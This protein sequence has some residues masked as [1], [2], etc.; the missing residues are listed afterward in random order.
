MQFDLF[1]LVMACSLV[2]FLSGAILA[3]FWSRTM[4]HPWL[5]MWAVAFV[6]MALSMLVTMVKPGDPG[7]L[8]SAIGNGL[9]MLA[10]GFI[11]SA[12]RLFERRKPVLWAVPIPSFVWMG[13]VNIPGVY[14]S[15]AIR[16]LIVSSV[17]SIFCGLSAWE[18]WRGRDEKLASKKPFLILVLLILAFYGG[19][20]P[21]VNTVPYPYGAGELD[22][23]VSAAMAA[24]VVA[25]ALAATILLLAMTLERK[26]L[27]QRELA[28]LDPLTGFLNRRGL[29]EALPDQRLPAG[30]ALILFD[31]DHFKQVN[32][33]FGHA[34]GDALIAGFALICR[35]ELRQID[36]AVRLGGEEF[37]LIL[38]GADERAAAAMAERVRTRY[39]ESVFP[40]EGGAIAGTVSGGYFCAPADQNVWLNAA[41]ASADRALY[42]AKTNGRNRVF[43]S[44]SAS[45]D[46]DERCVDPNGQAASA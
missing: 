2:V 33:T 26:E 40:I 36:H 37:A 9:L 41:I 25:A 31:F 34:A 24:I 44:E 8:S 22:D 18:L 12:L 16:V 39:G 23:L 35:E 13:V 42:R 15:L 28:T 27:T 21:L 46:F 10:F 3:Y 17:L 5:V 30:S 4:R 19:R 45:R 1:T 32:D 6:L 11:W 29:E 38:I 7:I 43:V 20:I 14:D